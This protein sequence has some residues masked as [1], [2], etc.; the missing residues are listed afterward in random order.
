MRAR[1]RRKGRWGKGAARRRLGDV[2]LPAARSLLW[3]D[4]GRRRKLTL[5]LI[6]FLGTPSADGSRS[7]ERG[8]RQT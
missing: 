8:E 6:F 7:C 2:G 1:R 5:A 3:E 4:G